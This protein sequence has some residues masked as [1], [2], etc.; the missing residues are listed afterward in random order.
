[1]YID[2][3]CSEI[4][5]VSSLALY[6][7]TTKMA[8]PMSKF[9]GRAS[10]YFTS[11]SAFCNFSISTSVMKTTPSK[12]KGTHSSRKWI[13]RQL[14]DPYVRRAKEVNYRCR[15]AFKLTE[16][17][18]IYKIIKPGAIVIDCGASPGSWS[19]VAIERSRLKPKDGSE[20]L[21]VRVI[22]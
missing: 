10:F 3:E 2:S 5:F 17:D 9:A 18:D 1:M 16:I 22:T 14:N 20:Y 4:V 6:I 15:S 12:F 7:M 19:Q 13:E 21:H 11:R 8:A